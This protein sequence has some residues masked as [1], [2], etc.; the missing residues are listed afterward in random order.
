MRRLELPWSREPFG[1]PLP[2]PIQTPSIPNGLAKNGHSALMKQSAARVLTPN[3]AITCPPRAPRI[4]AESRQR[5]ER[6]SKMVLVGV[7][8]R[9]REALDVIDR[10]RSRAHVNT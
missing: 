10:P 6:W 7:R 9:E 2:H 1:E 3:S 5:R 4:A 8:P